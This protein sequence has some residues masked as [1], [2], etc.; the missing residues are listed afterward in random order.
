MVAP[1]AAYTSA[2]TPP[3]PRKHSIAIF[4][5]TGNAGRAVAYQI[6]KSSAKSNN[7]RIALSGRNE[8]KVQ[9]TLIGIQDQLK[10]EGV[11]VSNDKIEIVVAD[12]SDEG[13][14]LSLAKSTNI[15]VSCLVTCIDIQILASSSLLL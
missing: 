7:V 10:S 1:T 8:H 2:I 15:L 14:M 3:G 9:E 5:C 12:A 6:I 13:S 4:G 11:R